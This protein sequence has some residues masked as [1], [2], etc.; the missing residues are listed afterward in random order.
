MPLVRIDAMGA[1]RDRLDALGRAVHDAMI[2]TI[3]IP[4]DD[5]FQVL[6]GHDGASGALRYDPDY[7]GVHR[8]NGIVFVAITLRSGRTPA[9]KQALYRRIAELAHERTGTAAR[10]VFITLTE[11]E[12]IDWSFGDGIAQYAPGPGPGA[13][14]SP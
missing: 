13:A 2:E 3:G 9:Q 11:N 1:N 12:P 4:P 7:L 5:L 6:A 14:G 10:N 8:D